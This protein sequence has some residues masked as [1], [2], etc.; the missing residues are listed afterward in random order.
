[1]VRPLESGVYWKDGCF[2]E[3]E[4]MSNGKAQTIEGAAAAEDKQWEDLKKQIREIV[5]LFGG[6][7]FAPVIIL[8]GICYGIR[9]GLIVGTEKT[10][11][12]LKG[13]GK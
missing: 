10:L 9:A 8:V 12:L 3:G 1:M 5:T 7:V 11:H 6:L 13:W 4:I 2:M